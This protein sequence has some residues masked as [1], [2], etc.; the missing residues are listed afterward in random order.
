MI[1][2]GGILLNEADPL[3]VEVTVQAQVALDEADVVLFMV[4]ATTGINPIDQEIADHLRGT[5]KPVL[6]VANK[7]DNLA[8]DQESSEFYQMGLGDVFPMSALNGRSV[9]DVLDEVVRVMPEEG[10][11][12]DT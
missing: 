7:A 9:A 12:S 3:K 1:D 6:V 10:P 2:T 4:D 5:T 11:E 8:L